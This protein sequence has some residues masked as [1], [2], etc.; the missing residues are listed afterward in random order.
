MPKAKRPP[1]STTYQAALNTVVEEGFYVVQKKQK[2]TGRWITTSKELQGRDRA[3]EEL[4]RC[5]RTDRHKYEWRTVQTVIA[6]AY[7]EGWKSH[8]D[9]I[10]GRYEPYDSLQD[11][12]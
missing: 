12:S 6:E 7:A 8:E 3:I 5:K 10:S 1:G 11:A 4:E 2:H 9:F